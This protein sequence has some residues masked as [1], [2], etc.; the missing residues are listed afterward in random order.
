MFI[1]L[2]DCVSYLF[3]LYSR[4]FF[5]FFFFMHRMQIIS[6]FFFPSSP[7]TASVASLVLVYNVC[8]VCVS[9]LDIPNIRSKRRQR[10]KLALFGLWCFVFSSFCGYSSV[11]CLLILSP[12]SL[13]R[14]H[15]AEFIGDSRQTHISQ[16]RK[17]AHIVYVAHAR[18]LVYRICFPHIP[19]CLL[20][21]TSNDAR[22][23]I[24]RCWKRFAFWKCRM[25][26]GGKCTTFTAAQ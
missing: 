17:S 1:K 12:A 4:R 2:A 25:V 24:S 18:M 13:R 26:Y 22:F 5:F 20:A 19:L 11:C 6:L 3:D 10:T 8:I 15:A 7:S 23:C 21:T 14:Y 16:T 9:T